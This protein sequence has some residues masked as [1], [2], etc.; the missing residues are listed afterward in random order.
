M[1]LLQAHRAPWPVVFSFASGQPFLEGFLEDLLETTGHGATEQ[2]AQQRNVAA[3][4][5]LLGINAHLDPEPDAIEPDLVTVCRP[6][7]LAEQRLE[8]ALYLMNR[9]LQPSLCLIEGTAV[10]Y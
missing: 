1:G 7:D 5:D 2:P 10:L 6:L 3:D 9:R 8:P 4:V